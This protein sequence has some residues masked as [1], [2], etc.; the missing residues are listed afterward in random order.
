MKKITKARF[1]LGGVMTLAIWDFMQMYRYLDKDNAL[2]YFVY[3]I[4]G[5]VMVIAVVGK[6]EEL[7]ELKIKEMS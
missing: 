1:G 4:M 6:I 3:L 7:I 5:I 2:M